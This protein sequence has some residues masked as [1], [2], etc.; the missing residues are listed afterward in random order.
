MSEGSGALWNYVRGKLLPPG[1]HATRIESPCSPGFPDVHYS[2]YGVSGTIELK[3]LRK[4]KLPFGDDGLNREQRAWHREAILQGAH[5]LI[6]A[7]VKEEIYVMSGKWYSQF[8][9]AQSLKHMSPLIFVKR[10]L[11]AEDL[12]LFALILR[13]INI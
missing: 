10:N 12:G 3:Y 9:E 11:E 4:K 6:V 13:R 2:Y 7:E 8:N 1:I 5:T